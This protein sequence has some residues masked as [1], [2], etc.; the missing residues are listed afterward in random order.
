MHKND[1]VWLS[2]RHTDLRR[3]MLE[4]TNGH[5]ESRIFYNNHPGNIRISGLVR[6]SLMK[7]R[8]GKI[9]Y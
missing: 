5:V 1:G 8:N 7:I 2:V 6:N 4:F 9:T 3:K